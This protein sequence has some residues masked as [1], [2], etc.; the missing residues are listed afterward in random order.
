MSAAP[1][2]DLL[3][4]QDRARLA[5]YHALLLKW[6]PSINLVAPSTLPDAWRRHFADSAQLSPLLPPK[7]I[8]AD[9]GSGG[10]FPGLVLSVLRPDLR[11]SLIEAD[12]RK[13]AFLAEVAR[14]TGAQVNLVNKRIEESGL[15]PFPYITARAF[16]PLVRLLDQAEGLIDDDTTGLFLKG[17]SAADELTEAGKSWHSEAELVPST[18]DARA[19]VMVL[20]HLRQRGK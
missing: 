19:C 4:A 14:A 2:P 9:L 12:Q 15:G 3:T 7:A 11:V 17:V 20:R 6:T 18:T 1:P 5:P 10:G 16:A 8:L 13:C